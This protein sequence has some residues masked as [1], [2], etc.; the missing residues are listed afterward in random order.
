M[1]QTLERP[2]SN[3]AA[4]APPPPRPPARTTDGNGGYWAAF[5]LLLGFLV[6][7]LG[8][9]A[10]W[11]GVSAHD[12]KNDA[13]R[14]VKAVVAGTA[15]T[16]MSMSGGNDMTSFAGQRPANADVL[17]TRHVPRTATLPPAP[18][19]PVA[20]VHLVLRAGAGAAS[21]AGL[22]DLERIRGAVQL[23]SA[24]GESRR[25]G[26]LLGRRRGAELRRRL[27]HRRHNPEP[28]VDERG[29]D[30]LSER[31]PDRARSGGRRR[32][33]RRQDRPAG[34]LSVR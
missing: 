9:V 13:N 6:V 33:V 7:A 10:V 1:P 32:S 19:G 22:G 21:G 4:H 31:H 27:P 24:H 15:T 26:A 25:N 18:A 12:A 2:T 14:A 28:R 5:A 23:A 34:A 3:G 29:H 20:R 30:A 17:A 16:G 11:M 8:S